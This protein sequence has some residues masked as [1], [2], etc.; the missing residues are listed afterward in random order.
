MVFA[1]HGPQEKCG[2]FSGRWNVVTIK[3]IVI[4]L[5]EVRQ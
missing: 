5:S 2:R 3:M 1:N 4:K